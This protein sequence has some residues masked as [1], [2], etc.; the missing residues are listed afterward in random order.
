MLHFIYYHTIYWNEDV[1]KQ[2]LDHN[3]LYPHL[4]FLTKKNDVQET[5]TMHFS[6]WKKRS[7]GTVHY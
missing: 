7:S 4:H 2:F 1:N 6:Y 5:L 3:I